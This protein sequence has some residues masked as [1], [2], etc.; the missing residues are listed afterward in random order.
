MARALGL[1]D[2]VRALPVGP[3]YTPIYAKGVEFGKRGDVSKGKA[4]HE[5]STYRKFSPADVAYYL[6]KEPDKFKAVGLFTGIRS[7]GIVILDVDANLTSLKAKWGDSLA[8]APQVVSTRKNAAKYVFR[9][10]EEHRPH[11]KGFSK[12]WSGQ[13]YEAL[14]GIQGVIAGEY[15]GSSDGSAPAGRYRLVAGSFDA[16]PDAPGWLLAE[17]RA[18]HTEDAPAKGLIKNR[19]GLDFSGRT[20]D[21]LAEIVHDCLSV[22]PHLGRGSEDYWW[23]VGAMVAETLPN[24]LGLTLWA[25]WSAQDPA[26]E[27]EWSDGNPCESRWTHL[28]AKAGRAGNL[29]LGSLIKEADRY[30][31]ERQRFQDSSRRTIEEVE[32]TQTQQVRQTV[33]DFTE[34]VKRARELMQ[35]DNPAEMN[36]RLHGLAVEAGYRD[37]EALERLLVDQMQYEAQ[38]DTFTL[39]ELLDQD[40]SRQFVI[41]DLLYKPSVVLLYGAG[42]DGK[43]MTAW[44]LA[45]HVAMGIPFQVKGKPVPIEQGHVLLLNG[46][47][48]LVQLQEQM[49][50]VEM[51]RSAPLTIRTDWSLLYY[52]RFVKLMEQIK[53]TLVV[54]DSLI[55]CSGGKAF[56]E[57]KSDFAT[58]LYW[59][60]RNN[61]V[62]FPATSIVVIH[63][64][65]KQGGFRGTS[66]INDAVDEVWGLRKPAD[67]E[68]EHV[69]RNA[70][71]VT[72]GKSRAGRSGSCLLLEQ[73]S[74]LTFRLSDWAAPETSLEAPSGVVDRVLERLRVVYPATRTRADLCADP[75]C[76]GSVAAIRKSLQR[77]VKRGLVRV[78]RT[79]GR[80]AGGKPEQHF[81]A[82]LQVSSRENIVCSSP[83]G[84]EPS[85]EARSAMGHA[86]GQE[87]VCPI[88]DAAFSTEAADFSTSK[89]VCVE[90]S[91]ENPHAAPDTNGTQTRKHVV[92]PIAKPSP[93]AAS[94]PMGRFTGGI[95]AREAAEDHDLERASDAAA[96]SS[97]GTAALDAALDSWD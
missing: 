14:W 44:T 88:G 1:I 47:Q 63:H 68:I 40:V 83:I 90:N 2:F 33:L 71:V 72:V 50:E 89:P 97:A 57:N 80:L 4:P 19:R 59:L 7:D 74:D 87:G 23:Q 9:V 69:G 86:M 35:L 36:Y 48:S 45:K 94:G 67:K 21:E 52:A 61:G 65:N 26:F 78:V 5:S 43:S 81:A 28:V 91:V 29:G 84:Q 56:D 18:K 96:E 25:A 66:A 32:A 41:P 31:A 24:D 55:G 42:G 77:L 82:V 92:C 73:Q 95:R 54:I 62:L 37:K 85:R 20:E 13:G 46:D 79:S 70:R 75:L 8:G 22:L 6:E 16:I 76:G 11:V 93:G 38:S 12:L 51:P 58:P 15:P 64:A 3:A 49:E 60:T 27:D 53:P 10:P 17:M 39:S 34:V 30:D